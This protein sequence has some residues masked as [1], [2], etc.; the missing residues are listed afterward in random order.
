MFSL[1]SLFRDKPNLTLVL[2]F[3]G[4]SVVLAY[5]LWVFERPAS[6]ISSQNYNNFLDVIWN[7][8]VTM[9][10]VGYGDI[11]PKSYG[12]WIM[13]TII[14]LWGVL[15]V[16]LFVVTISQSLEFDTPQKNAFLLLNKL[17]FK[18]NLRKDASIAL[19]SMY[20]YNIEKRVLKQKSEREG[21]PIWKERRL[22]KAEQ[23]FKRCL[24]K[25]KQ[26]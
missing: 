5:M 2:A 22:N 10:T 16:S 13:G 12:G 11:W 24:L 1:W 20:W 9:T 18:E 25:L 21:K 23:D 8:V 4:S 3:V 19:S 6:E 17:I 14:C 15:L 26:R 7:V